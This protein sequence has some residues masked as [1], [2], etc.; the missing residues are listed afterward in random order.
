MHPLLFTL[1]EEDLARFVAARRAARSFKPSKPARRLTI[2][3]LAKSWNIPLD[4]LRSTYD[5]LFSSLEPNV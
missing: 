5:E 2:R 1:T 4:V 3:E